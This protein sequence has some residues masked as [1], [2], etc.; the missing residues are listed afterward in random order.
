MIV[1]GFP[2][3]ADGAMRPAGQRLN[4]AIALALALL[5]RCRAFGRG[6]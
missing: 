3:G 1:L 4:L 6:N 5:Y 2:A